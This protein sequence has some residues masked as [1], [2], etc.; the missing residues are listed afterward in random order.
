[1]RGRGRAGTAI[2]SERVPGS[3]LDEPIND[4][5]GHEAGDAVLKA[6]AERLRKSLR[7]ADTAARLGG[8]EFAVLLVDI[9][10]EHIGVVADRIMSNLLRPLEFDCRLLDVKASLGVAAANSS[11]GVGGDE[12]VRNADV[13]M[14]VSKHGGK[15]RLSHYEAA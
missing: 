14:Y 11:S 8:D 15:G 10:E 12:L 7:R 1:V 4:T 6:A 13:A 5:Y 3:F 9:A 2:L